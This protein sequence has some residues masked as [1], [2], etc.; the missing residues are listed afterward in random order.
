MAHQLPLFAEESC[1]EDSQDSF[2][3]STDQLLI[4]TRQLFQHQGSNAELIERVRTAT[5][6]IKE[7]CSKPTLQ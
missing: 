7:H 3:D 6:I 1:S 2:A 5:R 4:Q